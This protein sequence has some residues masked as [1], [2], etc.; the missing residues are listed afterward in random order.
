M[1]QQYFF[2]VADRGTAG[3]GIFDD[4]HGLVE[5]SR[6]VDKDVADPGAGLDAWDFGILGAAT[7]EPCTSPWNQQVDQT[8]STHEFI[9]TG[10]IGVLNKAD[11]GGRESCVFKT[12]V[13][14]IDDSS[15]G[16]ESF[17]SATQDDGVT[18]LQRQ[19][20]R[21][22]SDIG[23]TFVDN[24][25]DAQGNRG[26]FNDETVGTLNAADDAAFRIGQL[27]YLPY[28]LSHPG[29]AFRGQSEA[30][31]HDIAVT[32]GNLQEGRVL[33]LPGG[34]QRRQNGSGLDQNIVCFSHF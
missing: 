12:V 21:I 14:S 7:N 33:F 20:S 1:D 8:D 28:A 9:G 23:T 2:R 19:N 31:D 25:D 30:V 29:N 24:G 13:D 10:V 17:P 5:I 27:R 4:V 18:G 3:L 15:V 32:I 11:Q 26:L 34:S 22:R 6:G 16:T